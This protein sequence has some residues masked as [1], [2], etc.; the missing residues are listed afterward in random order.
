MR[1][2]PSWNAAADQLRTLHSEHPEAARAADGYA[3]RYAHRRAS[4][5]FDVV[6]SHRRRYREVVLPAVRRFEAQWPDLTLAGLATGG[7]FAGLGLP[8]MRWAT[9]VRVSGGFERYRDDQPVL[10]DVLDDE[11]VFHWATAVEA[12]RLAPRLDSYVGAVPGIGIALFAYLRMRSGADAFKPDVRIRKH[13]GRL[14]FPIPA[15]EAALLLVGEAAAE[16]L[17]IRRLELDQLLW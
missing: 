6:A 12:V 1:S 17:A 7:P 11:L 13:L 8:A 9:I 5:V 15:G 16:E 2:H 4:M 3:E 10:A 14:R